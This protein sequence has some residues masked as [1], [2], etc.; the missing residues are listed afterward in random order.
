MKKNVKTAAS[1]LLAL[2]LC[3]FSSVETQAGDTAES[4]DLSAYAQP[5]EEA[6]EIMPASMP[7]VCNSQEWDLLY[8]TNKYR[9]SIGLE[10]LSMFDRL[11]NAAEVRARELITLFDHT[12]PNGTDCYSALGEAGVVYSWAG[13]NIAAGYETPEVT[14][15]AWMNSKSHRENILEPAFDHLGTGYVTGGSY[16]RNWVQLF[17]GQ[18]C[19]VSSISVMNPGANL[20]IG[21]GISVDSLGL[22]LQVV[23]DH[24]VSYLPITGEMCYAESEKVG[25]VQPVYVKYKEQVTSFNAE[26]GLPFSDTSEKDWFL[27]SVKY[28]YKRGIMSGL[29]DSEFGPEQPLARAQFAVILHRMNDEPKVDYTSKFSDVLKGEWYANAILWA[30]GTGVVTGYTNGKFGPADNITREQM[31][32][33][34]YRYARYKGYDTSKRADFSKFTDANRVSSFA[35]KAMQWAFGNGIITGK[36]NGTRLDPQGNANRAEC[37]AIIKRFLQ[38]YK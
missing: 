25:E 37:A 8:L 9:M 29:N 19:Q 30:N 6:A 12:R 22:V 32:L 3:A 15:N 1:I 17:I 2:T 27:S 34:M 21:D 4:I 36:D 31:A 35:E 14:V 20:K 16:R 5:L 18:S 10:P 13:E 26:V 7:S 33:M 11:Q 24:G 38:K 23:C 28:V